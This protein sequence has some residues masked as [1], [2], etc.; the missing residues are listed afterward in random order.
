MYVNNK[1]QTAVE[2]VDNICEVVE[3]AGAFLT[4]GYVMSA[5][6]TIAE[7]LWSLC[8]YTADHGG[9]VG[10]VDY[11]TFLSQT[12]LSF[13]WHTRATRRG[14]PYYYLLSQ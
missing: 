8:E 4:S 1:G 3:I 6:A 14:S 12:L 13:S 5:C 9:A 10:H 7:N 2:H 11:P